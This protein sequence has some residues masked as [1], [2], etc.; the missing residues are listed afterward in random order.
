MKRP[1]TLF[2]EDTRAAEVQR[3]LAIAEREIASAAAAETSRA[4]TV[5]ERIVRWD[6]VRTGDQVLDFSGQL[7]TATVLPLGNAWCPEGRASVCI[8]GRWFTPR[9]DR[10]TAVRRYEEG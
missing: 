1:S 5:A 9:K 2:A 6:E 4:G 10:L 8:D 7:G 3:Q